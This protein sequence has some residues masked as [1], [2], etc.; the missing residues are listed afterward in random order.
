VEFFDLT[1]SP[2]VLLGRLRIWSDDVGVEGGLEAFTG[3]AKNLAANAGVGKN[4]VARMNER[5]VV[6]S[7]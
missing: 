1:T 3:E 7:L 4:D 6:V 5:C 2:A